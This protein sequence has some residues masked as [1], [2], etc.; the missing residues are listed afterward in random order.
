MKVSEVL[1]LIAV[2]VSTFLLCDVC[3]TAVS[4]KLKKRIQKKH[5]V[6]HDIEKLIRRYIELDGRVFELESNSC[7]N[8]KEVMNYV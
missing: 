4:D 3:K 2:A 7:K 8:S 6:C 1:A 5:E